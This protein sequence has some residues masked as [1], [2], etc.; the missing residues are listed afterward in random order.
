MAGLFKK[1]F[2]DFI[3][4]NEVENDNIVE[5]RVDKTPEIA[6]LID[7]VRELEAYYTNDIFKAK[8]SYINQEL[9]EDQV[10]FLKKKIQMYEIAVHM[11][12]NIKENLLEK[13]RSC[14]ELWG[15]T[16]YSFYEELEKIK[17]KDIFSEVFEIAQ[18]LTTVNVIPELDTIIEKRLFFYKESWEIEGKDIP[19]NTSVRIIEK[20]GNIE[21]YQ[22]GKFTKEIIEEGS[23][24]VLSPEQLSAIKNLKVKI[25]F[26]NPA[27]DNLWIRCTTINR[28]QLEH[29]KKTTFFENDWENGLKDEFVYDIV[30]YDEIEYYIRAVMELIL[31]RKDFVVISIVNPNMFFSQLTKDSV[32]V[33]LENRKVKVI[34]RMKFLLRERTGEYGDN[35]QFEYVSRKQNLSEINFQPYKDFINNFLYK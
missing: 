30:Q 35:L 27:R 23:G 11:I 20:K 12:T 34:D 29:L 10:S 19:I 17:M 22:F 6:T 14:Q 25:S 33:D 7:F 3:G 26:E 28:R 32:F 2:S 18:Q 1:I 31:P 13:E 21:K 16:S 8:S 4:E 24:K 15:K 9:S 5:G